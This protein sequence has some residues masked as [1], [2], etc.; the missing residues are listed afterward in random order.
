[1]VELKISVRRCG[2]VAQPMRRRPKALAHIRVGFGKLVGY[3]GEEALDCLLLGQ[4]NAADHLLLGRDG[5]LRLSV[6]G[7][8]ASTVRR[9]VS[10]SNRAG[11]AI[12]RVGAL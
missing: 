4:L 2:I 1:M 12:R 8:K 11:G 5:H 9:P 6:G 3:A 7:V 10:L